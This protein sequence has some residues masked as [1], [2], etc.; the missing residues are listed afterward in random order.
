MSEPN[1]K[2]DQCGKAC[3]KSLS[4]LL[5]YKNNFCS[6]SCRGSFFNKQQSVCCLGCGVSFL[7]KLHEIERYPNHYCSRSCAHIAKN[8]QQEVSCFVCLKSFMKQLNQIKDKPRH[9]C[10]QECAKL[11][12]KYHKDWGSKRSK[13][14]IELEAV[15]VNT[16]NFE[17][18]FNK[19]RIVY[20]LD[21]DIPILNLAFELNG[22]FHYKAIYG[23]KKLL[24]VQKTDREKLE[25]SYEMN[26]DLIV[27]N[28]SE[29]NGS[30]KKRNQRIL[31]V[32][33]MI[34][35]RIL[36]MNYKPQVKQLAMEF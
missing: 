5:K 17:I 21:L 7:K 11:L 4:Q 6:R 13:L 2:C 23:E 32:I 12:R 34:N 24:Q 27:I 3:Y 33:A 22:V 20:E 16:Y 8:K 30:K 9:C 18:L 29:D 14:E 19:S 36:E 1:Y 35:S 10:S 26:F 15:L 25:K 31:E 28:V